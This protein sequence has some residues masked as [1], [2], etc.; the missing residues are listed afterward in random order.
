MKTAADFLDA[1]RQKHGLTSDYQVAKLL[2][3]K[4]QQISTYRTGKHTFDDSMAAT[5]AALLD[6]EPGYVAACMSA[7][8]AQSDDARRM[9]EKVARKV[10]AGAALAVLVACTYALS[11]IALNS[12]AQASDA[13]STLY[14]MLNSA[15]ILFALISSS[16]LVL[17]G[18]NPQARPATADL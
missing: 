9:W 6:V 10:G 2:G 18:R 11:P 17:I 15:G 13:S 5:V 12:E 7:Q 1:L 8:R 16:Y 3:L 14:I 4:P